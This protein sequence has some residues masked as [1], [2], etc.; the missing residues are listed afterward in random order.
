MLLYNFDDMAFPRTTKMNP[1]FPYPR[2]YGFDVRIPDDVRVSE[3][4][5]S[6][7]NDKHLSVLRNAFRD[8]Q[9]MERT[10]PCS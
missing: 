2:I 10:M 7:T 1:T 6:P 5:K 9:V 4:K 8:F 3:K